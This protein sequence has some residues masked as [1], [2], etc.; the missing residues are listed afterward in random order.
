[1]LIYNWN[2]NLRVMTLEHQFKSN[3]SMLKLSHY[4]NLELCRAGDFI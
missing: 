1:M 3:D 2:T 4:V